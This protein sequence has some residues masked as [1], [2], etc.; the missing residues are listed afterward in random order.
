MTE[1]DILDS[2]ELTSKTNEKKSI[3]IEHKSNIRFAQLLEYSLNFFKKF[4]I[5]K[6]DVRGSN[7]ESSDKHQDLIDILELL[8]KREVVG[9]EAKFLVENFL[10]DC[11]IQQQKWYSRVIQKDLRIG[12]STDT[13]QDCG[14]SIP[15]FDVMLAKDAKKMTKAEDIVKKGVYVS[16][17]LD[18]YRCLAVFDGSDVTLYSRN[19]SVFE[20]FPNIHKTLCD[21]LIGKA[22]PMVLDGEIMSDDF[23]SMQKSAFASVRGTTVGDVVYHIFG[24]IPFH[25]WAND[26]FEATTAM[27]IGILEDYFHKFLRNNDNL[28]LVP[29]VY[30]KSWD[31]ILQL[32][33]Q[34]MNQGLEGAMALPAESPYYKGRKTNQLM[35]FKTFFSM[36]CK[37]VDKYEGQNKYEG[38][39][40]GLKVLQEDGKT[41]CGVGS[42][43]TDDDRDY[44]WNN[45][46][47]IEGRICEIRY[48]ELTEDGVMRFPVFI[49]WR[50]QGNGKK[51]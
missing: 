41:I 40:G 48:Q 10:T 1:L 3:L 30:T 22:F 15:K 36:D 49:R 42:G 9:L 17:K 6:I 8:R 43:F 37:V 2:L 23:Q 47:R 21:S 45:F 24:C 51:I 46:N 44:I 38:K 5:R 32:E 11:N 29:Q 31:Q 34:Y 28:Q 25:E 16:P 35:K 27:R 39:L 19:G 33:S 4:H 20:N 26:K 14:Y 18:G 13:A 50:D 12:V 7:P